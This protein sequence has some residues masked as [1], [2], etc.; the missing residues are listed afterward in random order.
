MKKLI[1]AIIASTAVFIGV[2]FAQVTSK[3]AAGYVKTDVPAGGLALVGMPFTS[4][5]GQPR[6]IDEILPPADLPQQSQCFVWSN[7]QNRYIGANLLPDF[8]VPPFDGSVTRWQGE[9]VTAGITFELGTAYFVKMPPA[10][11]GT[12]YNTGEVPGSNNGLDTVNKT[13]PSGLEMLVHSYPVA[14]KL[15]E[16]NLNPNLQD[17]VLVWDITNQ[18]FTGSNFLP[19]FTVPPFDGSVR[20]WSVDIELT[21][22]MGFFYTNKGGNL[23]WNEAK[24]YAWP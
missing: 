3:N 9:L 21:P 22:G 1:T 20:K 14:L 18:E 23:A 6:T 13:I 16:A 19:D 7:A 11:G 8:T 2:A 5:D 4:F 24:V 17:Q 15:S 12:V 10:Q